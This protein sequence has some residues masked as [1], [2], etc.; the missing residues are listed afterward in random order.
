MSREEWK[1]IAGYE[2]RYSVSSDGR[3]R[4]EKTGKIMATGLTKASGGYA[5]VKLLDGSG[6]KTFTVHRLVADA[7]VINDEPD[8]KVEVDHVNGNRMDNRAE[9]LNW[10]TRS[11]NQRRAVRMG[12]LDDAARKQSELMSSGLASRISTDAHLRGVYD[13]QKKRVKRSDGTIF[14]SI[15]EAARN[16]GLRVQSISDVLNGRSKTAGGYG[17]V[18]CDIN[19]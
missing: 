2:G 10:V 1:P 3:I 9:N 16:T 6:Q 18:P 5:N 11:E 17:F 7:F 4:S 14:N 15:A 8:K 19:E 12:L 13:F